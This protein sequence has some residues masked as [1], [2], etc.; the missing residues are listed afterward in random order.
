MIDTVCIIGHPSRLGGADTELDHQIYCW[1]AMGVDVHVCH[2]GP[3][4]ANRM[5][6]GQSIT[7][8]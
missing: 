2:T 8:P 1:Q 6:Y 7:H 3:I 4:D 5:F